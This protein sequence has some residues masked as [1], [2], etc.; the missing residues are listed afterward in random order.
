MA[1]EAQG[2]GF[3]GAADA[4]FTA[5]TDATKLAFSECMHQLE[6]AFKSRKRDLE[7][8][9]KVQEEKPKK[10]TDETFFTTETAAKKK[11]GGGKGAIKGEQQ[12]LPKRTIVQPKKYA[13]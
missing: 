12:D 2:E 1:E 9:A 11:R 13:Q 3:G 8:E 10:K 4:A 7:D 6:N 5:F